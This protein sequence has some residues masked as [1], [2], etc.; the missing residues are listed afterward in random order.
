MAEFDLLGFGGQTLQERLHGPG[1]ALARAF[2]EQGDGFFRGA[3]LDQ[4]CIE[5][6]LESQ[7]APGMPAGLPDCPGCQR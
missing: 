6:L 1:F 3:L 2:P 7:A 4:G 5:G